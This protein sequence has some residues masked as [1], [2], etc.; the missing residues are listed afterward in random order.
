MAI[1]HEGFATDADGVLAEGQEY[2]RRGD[3]LSWW[4]LSDSR[5]RSRGHRGLRLADVEWNHVRA[6][7]V[8][9]ATWRPVVAARLQLQDQPKTRAGGPGCG[10]RDGTGAPSRRRVEDRSAQD[11]CPWIFSRWPSRRRD[12]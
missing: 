3:G 4:R 9:R 7:E 10:T 6:A 8:P 5:H 2:R 1:H 12:Q 11:W